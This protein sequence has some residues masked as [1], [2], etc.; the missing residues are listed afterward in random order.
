MDLTTP[1]LSRCVSARLVRGALMLA[2]LLAAGCSPYKFAGDQIMKLGK[3]VIVPHEL[4]GSDLGIGCRAATAW[5][6]PGMAFERVGTDVN[7]MSVLLLV[8]AGVCTEVDAVE[9]ELAYLRAAHAQNPLAA[10]DAR[11]EQKRAHA[12]AARRQYD[13]YL[14]FMKHYRNPAEGKCP[15]LRTDFDELVFLV[16]LLGGVQ[17]VINDAQASQTVNVPRDIAPLVGHLS[18]CV[19]SDKWWDLPLAVRAAMWSILP[20]LAPPD[21]EPAKILEEVAHRGEREGVRLGHVVWAMSAWSGGDKATTRRAIR[22]FAQAGT[23][24]TPNQEYRIL[25]TIAGEI[26]L[27]ISDRMWTEAVGHR[28]PMNGLG[29]FWDD[30]PAIL[31]NVDD[32]L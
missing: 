7:Q 22:D 6:A 27:T 15:K 2:A 23:R 9:Y 24:F 28:T 20:M 29:T 30:T 16:G 26:M 17:A 1:M 25:D 10:Q 8:T 4:A 11:A 3:K 13:G 21:V 18:E 19:D 32:L 31:P 5:A 14:R 12:L